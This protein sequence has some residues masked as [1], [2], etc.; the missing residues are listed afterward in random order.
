MSYLQKK[1][2]SNKCKL[3]DHFHLT[4]EYRGATHNKCNLEYQ[5]ANFIP[6]SLQNLSAYDCHLFVR[7]LLPIEGDT[8]VLTDVHN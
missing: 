1:I 5:I 8:I 6:I 2:S 3:A 7:E 4:S